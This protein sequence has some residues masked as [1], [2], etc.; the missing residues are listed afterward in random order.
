MTENSDQAKRMAEPLVAG[1]ATPEED[2]HRRDDANSRS[3]PKHVRR[4]LIA[5]LVTVALAFELL[6]G[7]AIYLEIAGSTGIARSFALVAPQIALVILVSLGIL[8][9]LSQES[10][11]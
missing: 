3:W 10:S 5:V 6:L 2:V 1:S 9:A 4:F 7:V 8:A 11:T